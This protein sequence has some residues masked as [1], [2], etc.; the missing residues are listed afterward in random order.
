MFCATVRYN[1]DP[2]DEFTDAEILD[3]LQAVNLKE[4][5]F[6]M[7]GG[8]LAPVDEGGENLSLGQRQLICFARALLRRPKV[9]VLDEATASVDNFADAHIQ[10][11][12]RERLSECTVLTIAH[13][14]HTIVDSDQILMLA[15]G[16]VAESGPPSEL[17]DKADGM[18]KSMWEI[19]KAAHEER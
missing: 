18:F 9:V 7:P 10:K 12:L 16:V 5:I 6:A 13:R 19:Y 8:L 4:V 3:V 17:L 15:D 1:L 2:L 14:L 11:M